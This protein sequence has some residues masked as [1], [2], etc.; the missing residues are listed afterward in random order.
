[1]SR[2]LTISKH[3]FSRMVEG[4]GEDQMREI[5]KQAGK[6]MRRAL[7][8]T[9]KDNYSEETFIELIMDL[10]TYSSIWKFSIAD[11]NEH[12]TITIT[13]DLGRKWSA[14]VS[15]FIQAG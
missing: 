3:T 7:A 2:T 11:S 9:K 13:H 8:N 14:Y 15:K 1:M 5:G 4:I 10:A 12:R 6:N